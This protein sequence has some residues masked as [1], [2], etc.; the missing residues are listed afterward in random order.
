MFDY[1]NLNIKFWLSDIL[2]TCTF[3]H[4]LYSLLV[5]GL[6]GLPWLGCLGDK[7]LTVLWI[8]GFPYSPRSVQSIHYG[9]YSQGGRH[10]RRMGFNNCHGNWLSSVHVVGA[11]TYRHPLYIFFFKRR[12]LA[13]MISIN[14]CSIAIIFMYNLPVKMSQIFFGGRTWQLPPLIPYLYNFWLQWSQGNR[15]WNQRRHILI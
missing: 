15:S 2:S 10:S 13:V 1:M 14:F 12:L 5:V 11:G 8:T 6:A 7:K 3:V 4:Y 9:G